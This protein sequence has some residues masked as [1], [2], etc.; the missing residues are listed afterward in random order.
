MNADE[1]GDLFEQTVQKSRDVLVDKAREY[2]N[3][4]DRLHNFVQAAAVLQTTRTR[5]LGGM[6]LKHTISV[7]DMINSGEDYP[8][9][10]W[11]EKIMDHINYLVLLRACICDDQQ[12]QQPQELITFSD[13]VNIQAVN[14]HYARLGKRAKH[15]L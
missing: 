12:D 15:N 8:M 7:Y 14:A 1:F 9:E 13:D 10:K 3:D 4:G 6:M 2:A 11:D 5:A